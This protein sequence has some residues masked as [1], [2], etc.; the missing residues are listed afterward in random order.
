M[1]RELIDQV[2]HSQNDKGKEYT[3]NTFLWLLKEPFWLN[4]DSISVN[5]AGDAFL[6]TAIHG[7]LC[8]KCKN[9]S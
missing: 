8:I 7:P 4:Y 1:A 2:K 3:W 9:G 6:E 5:Q